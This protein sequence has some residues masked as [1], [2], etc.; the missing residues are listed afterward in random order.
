MPRL[1]FSGLYRCLAAIL[2]LATHPGRSNA[3]VKVEPPENPNNSIGCT[4]QT[5]R[6]EWNR[7][8]EAVVVGKIENL[9]QEPLE[10]QLV[11]ELYLSS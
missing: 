3:Q 11:P 9:T 10:L 1:K 5:E 2:V 7:N 8:V 4:I 6:G